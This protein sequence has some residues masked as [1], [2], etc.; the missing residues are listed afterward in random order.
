MIYNL[1]IIIRKS[2][3]VKQEHVDVILYHLCGCLSA[4]A[5]G[6]SPRGK[7]SWWGV[8]YLK[9]ALEHVDEEF[10]CNDIELLLILTLNVGLS[11]CCSSNEQKKTVLTIVKQQ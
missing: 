4:S 9:G 6:P 1:N 5:S 10:V 2:L 7:W 3:L 11:N 8:A